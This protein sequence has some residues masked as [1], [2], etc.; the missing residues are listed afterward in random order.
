MA[1]TTSSSGR[2]CADGPGAAPGTRN[3]AGDSYVL[4]GSATIG[5]SVNHVTHAGTAASETLTG[6]GAAN[7]MVGG[8]GHDNL[9]GNGGADVLIGGQGNDV[10]SIGDA[11]F[12]RVDG[13]TGNDVLGISGNVTLADSDFRRVSEVE[14]LR[15]GNGA[16]SLTLGAIVSRA[17]DGLAANNFLVAI[18]GTQVTSG[19]VTIDATALTRPVSL[20]MGAAN[21]S[22]TIL[23][24]A[25]T[26]DGGGG[27]DTV[28]AALTYA[29]GAN[30]EN[31][32]LLGAA[33]INGTGNSLANTITGNGA[34]NILGGGTGNDTLDGG[35][36][37]DT[38]N[39]GA[40]N[41]TYVIDNV[42]DQ[43]IEAA[44]AGTDL[45]NSSVTF[46]LGVN[47][48]NLTLL[49]ASAINGT[50]NGL[51]NTITGNG[52]ANIL[53]GGTGNDIL[54]GKG[55]SDRLIG[56]A[57]ND[58][59]VINSTGDVLADS[60]GVDLVRST[61]T[62]T[63]AIGFEKLTLLGGAALNGTGNA[64][65]NVMTGNTG[66]N[67][68]SGLGG[69]DTLNGGS[70]KD[71]LTGGVGKDILNGGL[72]IDILTGGLGKDTMTGGAG[73]DDFDFNS[74]AEIGK[75]ATR[76]I[77]KDFAHLS[78]DIDLATIDANGAAAGNKFSF[79]AV[80]G[81]LFNGVAG[82]LR[83]FQT[84]CT[85]H[86]QRQNN[87]RRRHQRQ[88][89]RRFS[90]LTDRAQIPHGRRLR[91]LTFNPPASKRCGEPAHAC[92]GQLRRCLRCQRYDRLG[93]T[94]HRVVRC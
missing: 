35:P 89:G 16:I 64:A 86:R 79:L 37:A 62:K 72:G 9:L 11:T 8:R 44:S 27:I 40:E 53:G 75:G 14:S 82:E 46:T 41:D 31:L 19:A 51:A 15:L 4:F 57:G 92:L 73:A 45:V 50:G 20:T 12:Q 65:A 58:T 47:V 59:F 33:A 49:G 13:G 24:G 76:D 48:E 63:L 30:T 54:D 21:D 60:A 88:Q 3:Y 85:G 81:D 18:D 91:S 52:A 17:I 77:I 80:K 43:A 68:L 36:G 71:T 90:D 1:S 69:N 67:K 23:G 22:I 84:N 70:G 25:V 74:V 2:P 32:T 93:P 6:D 42:S 87:C 61:V 38:L 5:G 66:N 39:G 55:G 83:W 29:L 7:V 94:S 26:V 56:G 34:A 78:D 28:S 10:L